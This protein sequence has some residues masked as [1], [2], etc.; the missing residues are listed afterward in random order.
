MKTLIDLMND[1]RPWYTFSP[2]V[3][4]KARKSKMDTQN[5]PELCY[6]YHCWCKG[7]CNNNIDELCKNVEELLKQK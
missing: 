7:I 2:E 1:L 4:E 5:S 3:L 6:Y